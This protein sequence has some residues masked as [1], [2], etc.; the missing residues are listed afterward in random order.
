MSSKKIKVAVIGCG[1]IS[2]SHIQACNSLEDAEIAAIVDNNAEVVTDVA[3][4]YS[5]S[6]HYTNHIDL[7]NN[8]SFNAAIVCTPPVTHAPIVLDLI[9]KGIN[10]LCEKPFT[11]TLKDAKQM[12]KA[13][14]DKGVLLMMA[15]KFRFVEDVVKAH[16]IIASGILG[17]IIL[18]ENVFCSKVNMIGRWNSIRKISGGGVLIDNGSHAV[19][20]AS[21]LV[22]EIVSVQTQHGKQAQPIEVEDTSRFYIQTKTGVLG[23]IDLSWSIHKETDAYISVY[24]TEGM[25][26]VGWKESRYRQSEKLN[27]VT[28]GSGYNKQKAFTKQ[29]QHFVNCL[30]KRELPLMTCHDAVESVR[31]IEVAYQSSQSNK[32]LP[33][34]ME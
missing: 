34:K 13:A 21:Y 5:L 33:V 31:V 8:E 3:K 20:V 1:L 25:L 10:I 32:W 27:W 28:F 24:G 19:D 11:I 30:L 9:N 26:M 6:K 14:N 12:E 7:L 4:K 23:V 15:S 29:L 22:G 2:H 18:Y 16:D 17:N